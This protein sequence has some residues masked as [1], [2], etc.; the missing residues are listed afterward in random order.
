METIAGSAA[1]EVRTDPQPSASGGTRCR[2]RWGLSW[3][4]LGTG[5]C[6]RAGLIDD[7]DSYDRRGSRR[8][9]DSAPLPVRIRKQLLSLAE[10]PLRRWHDE[11][12]SIAQLVAENYDNEEVRKIFIDLTLQIA[13]E[14]PLKT[15]FVAAVILIV[16]TLKPAVVEELLA[17]AATQTEERA[18][19]GDWSEVK[20][21]LKLLACLHSCLAGEGIFPL[22]EELFSRAVDLQTASSE[23]VRI[24]LW[25]W[26]VP[27]RVWSC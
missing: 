17:K 7:D 9:L 20:L 12:Q 2:C 22:L 4:Q 16:N 6:S 15:P 11:V 19:A 1:I 13:L 8:R 3:G 23:D 26:G 10:S 5:S 27:R 18:K 25:G 21:Y 24:G 14:Q